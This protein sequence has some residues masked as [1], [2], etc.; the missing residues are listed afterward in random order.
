MLEQS[1]R[2]RARR[3]VIDKLSAVNLGQ[4]LS[5]ARHA[6]SYVFP[7][8]GAPFEAL[9]ICNTY[10]PYLQTIN[11]SLT[12]LQWPESKVRNSMGHDDMETRH[13]DI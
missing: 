3:E 1:V 11:V 6:G 12:G 13:L 7:C 2:K 4:P 9:I 8:V 10:S 5:S